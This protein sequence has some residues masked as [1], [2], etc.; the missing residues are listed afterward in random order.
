MLLVGVDWA[1]TQH[2][3]CLL[4]AEGAGGPG[5]PSAGAIVRR[6]TIPHTAAGMRRLGSAIAALET[7]AAA[8]LV[9]VERADGLLVEWL[10]TAGYVVYA[11]PPKAVQRY[12]ERTRLAWPGGRQVRPGRRRA[13]RAHPA[14]RPR[15]PPAAAPKQRPR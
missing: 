14:D 15:P 3:V 11:L 5:S 1:E 2:A 6:L 7:D 10:L 13:A 8:V 12:R 9:A 4:R